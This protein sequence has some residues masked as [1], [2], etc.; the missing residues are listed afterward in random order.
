MTAL[1]L[2]GPWT[3]LLFQGEEFGACT[4]FLFFADTGEA[5]VREATR[6]GRAELLAPFLSLAE[7]ETLRRLPAPDDP[8][9]FS[10]C[11]LDFAERDKNSELYDLHIDLLKLRREDS[12]FR[13][14]RSVGIDGAVLGPASFVLRYFS[15]ENDDRLLLVNLGER[16]VLHPVSEPLLAPPAGHRWETLWTSD[17]PRYGGANALATATPEQWILPAESSVAFRPVL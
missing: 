5:S 17:S 13:Q 9:A 14:Q 8:E 16:Q 10:R 4:P 15:K 6:K 2:L 7:E 11:K 1:L 12:R 3:P